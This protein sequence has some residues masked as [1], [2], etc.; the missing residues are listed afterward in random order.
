MGVT[1]HPNQLLLRC[2][3]IPLKKTTPCDA[4]VCI[5]GFFRAC[6][7]SRSRD[8][9]RWDG[10]AKVGGCAVYTIGKDKRRIKVK[11]IWCFSLKV[12]GIVSREKAS[13]KSGLFCF[14]MVRENLGELENVD[15]QPKQAFSWFII[16]SYTVNYGGV[17]V[18]AQFPT[19]FHTCSSQCHGDWDIPP[20]RQVEFH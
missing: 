18:H 19:K 10:S 7:E 20:F 9:R 4:K 15:F 11:N 17:G 1:K 13:R 16:V 3:C 2:C 5:V 14:C 8:R 6:P 12:E